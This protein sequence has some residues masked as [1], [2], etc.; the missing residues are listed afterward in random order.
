MRYAQEVGP[1]DAGVRIS[2]R[3]RYPD[4]QLGD[5]LGVLESWVDGVVTVVRASGERVVLA[6]ADVVATRRIPPPP[7]RR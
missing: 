1:G 5:V 2:L 7:A 6:E 4:G 3:R